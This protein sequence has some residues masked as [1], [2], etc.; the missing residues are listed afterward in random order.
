MQSVT[1]QSVPA[2]RL[3]ARIRV[4]SHERGPAEVAEPA[5]NVVLLDARGAVIGEAPRTAVHTTA[6]PRHLI[7]SIYLFDDR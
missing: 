5:D 7:F 6:T 2:S 3:R 4:L 1:V